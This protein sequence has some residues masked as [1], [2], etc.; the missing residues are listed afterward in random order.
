MTNGTQLV[1]ILLLPPAIDIL[2]FKKCQFSLKLN[3]YL[4]LIIYFKGYKD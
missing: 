1:Q 3:Y 4:L 2:N